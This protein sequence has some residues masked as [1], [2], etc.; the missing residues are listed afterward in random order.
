MDKKKTESKSGWIAERFN[1]QP[2]YDF[3]EHKRVPVHK[4]SLWYYMGGVSLFLFGVQIITGIFLLVYYQPGSD[5]SYESVRYITTQVPFGWLFRS[6]H[7]WSANLLMFFIFLHMF[8][9]FFSGA[10]RKPR[11]L[12]WLSGFLLMALAMGFGFSGYLLPWDELAFFATKVGTDIVGVL[13]F[14]GE[15]LK[16]LL[17]GGPDVTEATLARFFN[18][19]IS[20]LP[21]ITVTF[22]AVHLILIQ[23]QGMHEPKFYQESKEKK[24]IPFFPHFFLRD[25]LLW[26]IVLDVLIFLAVFFPWDLGPKA[27]PFTSAPA[28]IHPEWYFMFMFQALKFFPATIIGIEGELIG[29]LFF[30]VAGLLWFITPFWDQKLKG[31]ARPGLIKVVGMLVILFIIVMTILGYVL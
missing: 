6:L 3:I 13:P 23:I 31:K 30:G 21:I 28:G 18:I 22:L 25:A 29:I 14:V 7:S 26:L 17:R 12:T 27:D 9:V 19:H 11:E 15:A 5:H 16:E 10:F 8:S 1:L 24:S 20:I 4:H 2:L